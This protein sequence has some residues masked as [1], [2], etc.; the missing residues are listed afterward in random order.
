M[1]GAGDEIERDAGQDLRAALERER[2]Q[3]AAVAF[4]AMR[5]DV[6]AGGL[7]R[8]VEQ[9]APDLVGA[10]GYAGRGAARRERPALGLA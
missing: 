4:A 1:R 7:A 10:A 3:V 5:G 2:L 8:L 6:E 9:R